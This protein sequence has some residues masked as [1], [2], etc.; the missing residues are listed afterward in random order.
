M[1]VEFDNFSISLSQPVTFLILDIY[2]N[3]NSMLYEFS[4]P[5][6][7]T[8]VS[9]VQLVL[10]LDSKL[11]SSQDVKFYLVNLASSEVVTNCEG[12]ELF[13]L[14]STPADYKKKKHQK[15]LRFSFLG[16]NMEIVYHCLL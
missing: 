13:C 14:S 16:R 12:G 5:Y 10:N 6:L 8:K 7:P 15:K 2:Y 3:G 1:L 9:V 11:S 4:Q